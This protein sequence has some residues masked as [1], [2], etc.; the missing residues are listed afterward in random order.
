[1]QDLF[2]KIFLILYIFQILVQIKI[3]C[4]TNQKNHAKITVQTENNCHPALDA[5][6]PSDPLKQVQG[7]KSLKKLFSEYNVL[8]L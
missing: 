4:H 6:T 3:N 8:N 1:L 7:D 2:I 5:G